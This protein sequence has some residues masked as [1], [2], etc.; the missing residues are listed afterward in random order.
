MEEKCIGQRKGKSR[1]GKRTELDWTG[2]YLPHSPRAEMYYSNV[3][4]NNV[5]WTVITTKIS[6]NLYDVFRT[7]CF[8]LLTTAREPC[9][10]LIDT[11]TSNCC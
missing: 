9:Y 6:I 5:F 7:H 3:K 4:E 8:S 1:K 2:C 10:E 11:G